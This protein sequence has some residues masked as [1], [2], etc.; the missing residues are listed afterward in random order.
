MTELDQIRQL[1]DDGHTVLR[2][3]CETL[4]TALG[5]ETAV[6][7]IRELAEQMLVIANEHDAEYQ[8]FLEEQQGAISDWINEGIQKGERA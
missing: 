8:K 2:G 1:T 7:C 3:M 6:P 4:I 5:A